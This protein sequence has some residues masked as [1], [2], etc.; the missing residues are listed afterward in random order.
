MKKLASFF[1]VFCLVFSVKIFAQTAALA[2][3]FLTD[4]TGATITG[5]IH[6]DTCSWTVPLA[7]KDFNGSSAFGTAIRLYDSAGWAANEPGPVLSRYIQFLVKPQSGY[8]FHVDS[9]AFWL[10]CY[11][12]HG[13]MHGA[14]YWDK[15]TA[16][17]S[18]NN[19][20][21]YDSLTYPV[22]PSTIKGLP[23]IREDQPAS[24]LPHD[25]SFAIN[26]T[27]NNGSYFAMRV[28]PWYN[29]SSSSTSKYV[30][31]YDVRVYGTT[32]PATGIKNE[33]GV[34]KQFSL[35]QNY[36]NPFNPSTTISFDLPKENHV[37]LNIYNLLGQKVASLLNEDMAAGTHSVNFNADNLPSGLYFYQ[38]QSGNFNS[39]KKMMLLK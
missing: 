4:S 27:I 11:G 28:F 23:D 14:V 29:A 32:S 10:A 6:A 1:L 3:W 12:T 30:V 38:L 9:V 24:G 19:E 15:D 22:A 21:D 7:L 16:N 2:E 18:Q 26:T 35:N 20:L 36:P 37:T 25:T 34:P 31:L 5:S 17:F 13:N 33:P 39:I 8:N